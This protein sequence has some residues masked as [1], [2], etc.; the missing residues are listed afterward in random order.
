LRQC[1]MRTL[2]KTF[3]CGHLSY[4]HCLRP[5]YPAKEPGNHAANQGSIADGITGD[6]RHAAMP[7]DDDRG[8]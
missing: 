7:A 6:A 3:V 5:H 2:G 1:A 4:V 8:Q